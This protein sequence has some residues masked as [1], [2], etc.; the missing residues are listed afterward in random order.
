MTN[1]MIQ[2]EINKANSI[3]MWTFPFEAGQVAES[4]INDKITF[5]EFKTFE[6][7]QYAEE[8]LGKRY[9]YSDIEIKSFWKVIEAQRI[10]F[11]A[12]MLVY[13]G[14][15]IAINPALKSL[16]HEV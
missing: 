13:N 11:K 5:E 14:K 16:G 4:I 9:K 12:A 10:Y 3:G 6:G 7:A 1:E 2:K 15:F 8:Y